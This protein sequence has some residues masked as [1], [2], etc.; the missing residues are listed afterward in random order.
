MER[1]NITLSIPKDVLR[2]VKI[3]AIKH[4]KSL[5]GLL[6]QLLTDL[7]DDEAA[8]QEA[9]KRQHIWMKG[10]FDLGTMGQITW[11]REELYDR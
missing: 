1:Q 2:K 9:K 11:T 7:V 5:S 3:I 4:D 6:T 8:Y 10:G